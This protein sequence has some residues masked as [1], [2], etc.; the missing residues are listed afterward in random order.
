[1]ES[2]SLVG[3]T[4]LLISLVLLS[5]CVAEKCTDFPTVEIGKHQAVTPAHRLDWWGLRHQQIL[6]RLKKGN[7]DLIFIGD[8]ITHRWEHK[9]KKIWDQYYGKRNAV[10]MGFGGD[11]TQHVIWRLEH[12]EIDN[13][14]P[15]VAVLMIG[16]NNSHA[17]TPEEISDGIKVICKILRT[18]LPTTKILL[19]AIF[20][21]G[22]E[23]S[24]QRDT[25]DKASEIASEIA[26]GKMI[27]YIN[28]NHNFL[29]EDGSLPKEIMP[30]YL[31]PKA[32]GYEIWAE[33]ME[34][35]LAELMGEKKY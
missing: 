5:G 19:M 16:T 12:G 32:K 14:S 15:K 7:V 26:D 6:E 18:K 8:S 31:H 13:I 35:K 22:Q 30:D 17:N 24:P 4:A 1:M 11:T 34:L 10:N 33:A 27:H 20:P 23:P 29:A 21:R 3:Y 9:G 28:I 25:N 2:K